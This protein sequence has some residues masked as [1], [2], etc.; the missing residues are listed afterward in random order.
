MKKFGKQVQIEK[1][2]ERHAEKKKVLDKVASLRKKSKEN[3]GA[4]DVDFDVETL[5]Q[6]TSSFSK[7]V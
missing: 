5:D 3:G 1:V 7:K 2:K 6:P 4:A